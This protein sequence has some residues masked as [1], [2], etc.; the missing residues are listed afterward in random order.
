M[1]ESHKEHAQK[2]KLSFSKCFFQVESDQKLDT[3]I[4]INHFKVNLSGATNP[5]KFECNECDH[6]FE[7]REELVTHVKNGAKCKLN[8]E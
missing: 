6:Y 7:Q 5:D 3:H 2:D 1:Q 4:I 8:M